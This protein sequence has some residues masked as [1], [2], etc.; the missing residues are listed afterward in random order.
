[1]SDWK[2]AFSISQEEIK[3]ATPPGTVVLVVGDESKSISHEHGH[4]HG[5][6]HGGAHIRFPKPSQDAADPLNWPIWRKH[7]VL[8]VLSLYSFIAN[9]SAS[10]IAPA[11]QM[12][13]LFF[14][15]D[16]RPFP[17]LSRLIAVTVLLIGGAN[18][19]WVP[20]SNIIGHRPV[21][22]SSLL[23]LTLADLWCGL[24]TNY[25]SLLAARIFQGIG[26]AAADTVAPAIIGEVYFVDERGRA[27]AIY[28]LF[29][30][31]GS[32]VGGLSGG[33]IAAQYGWSY[34]FWID[35]GIAAGTLV[36]TFFLVPE[37]LY[38]RSSALLVTEVSAE[39]SDEAV[40]QTSRP[41]T[42]ARSLGFRKPRGN[43]LFHFTNPWRVLSLPGTWVVTLQ[44]GGLVGGI[45]TIST[46]GPQLLAMPPY[47]WG[48]NVGLINVGALIGTVLGCVYTYL[49]SDARLKASVSHQHQSH[50]Y[51]EPES[52][53]PTMFPS[54][55]IATAGFLVFGFCAKNPG[56]LVWVGLEFGH[57]MIAFGLMQAPSIGFSYLID[58][59]SYLAADCF[60]IAAILRAIVG[61][62]WS[63][64]VAE[65]VQNRGAAEPF[66]IF[67]LLMGVF[68]LLTI[69]LWLYGKRLR[70]A[71]SYR[72]EATKAN[73]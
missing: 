72:F 32:I 50:R 41:Y 43:V 7:A 64:F 62:A 48:N 39:A 47:L 22:L 28:T 21:L 67:A 46:I 68:S 2:H 20:L 30:A 31:T 60:V 8:L 55:A 56:P 65:W 4:G 14:P 17:V 27:L 19:W 18:I 23:I 44:Y 13:P 15:Q 70:I 34:I 69:P 24:A 12:W 45:V 16:I 3:T 33:N 54:L 26:A 6:G 38:D 37:T 52:R 49:V 66:G 9:F 63:F 25:D 42:F 29:L 61:F 73:W 1:M 53:L 57:G 58:A 59:Y 5:H 36:L 10:N 11:L 40:A 71:T 35:L 51:V